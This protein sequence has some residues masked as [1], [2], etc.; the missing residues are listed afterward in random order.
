VKRIMFS[1]FSLLLLSLPV[2]AETLRLAV[3]A[4]FTAVLEQLVTTF[5]PEQQ[6]DISISSASTGVLYTQITRG[7]PFDIFFAADRARPERLEAE[8]LILPGSRRTYAIGQLALWQP[9]HA[10]QSVTDLLPGRLAIA[11]PDTAPYGL[12]AQQTLQANGQW[13]PK[14]LVQGTNIAQAYQFVDSG[15]VDQGFVALSL[16][17]QQQVPAKHWIAVPGHLHD[18]IE[19]QLVQLK[20]SENNPL[21][22]RFLL[23][24]STPT[25]RELIKQ[26]GYGIVDAAH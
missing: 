13:E 21:A 23:F 4:N 14:R 6:H 7:A 12:A 8:G 1:F 25:A 10:P 26:R 18:P 16:L 3:A 2:N 24:L 9:K 11:N 15:N 17:L 5:D 19:Q 22:E 20:R